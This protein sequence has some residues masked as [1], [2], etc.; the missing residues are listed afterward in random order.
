MQLD[1]LTMLTDTSEIHD[2]YE[3]FSGGLAID[4]GAS[5]GRVAN[6]LADNFDRVIACEPSHQPFKLMAGNVARNVVPLEVAVSD[7]TGRIKLTYRAMSE[8]RGYLFTGDSL[9]EWG[10]STGE[11]EVA[12]VTLDD[13]SE[14]YGYP[15]FVKIDTEGHE[16]QV[17]LGGKQTFGR[18]PQFVIEI[19]SED[20]GEFVR[21]KIAGHRVVRHEKHEVD[22]FN[23]KNHYWIVST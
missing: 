18:R 13:L 6:I 7:E 4:V 14:S 2:L 20:N 11:V 1:A 21:R 8:G 17:V 5:G 12:S 22:S 19:H 16:V 23:W 15:D 3:T 9:P 10:H